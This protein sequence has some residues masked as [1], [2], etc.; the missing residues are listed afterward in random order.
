MFSFHF[1]IF[2]RFSSPF[3]CFL[4]F[5][6][7]IIV[8][9]FFFIIFSIQFCRFFRVLFVLFCSNLP[10]YTCRNNFFLLLVFL[11][12]YFI[13]FCLYFFYVVP[14]ITNKTIL[15]RSMMAWLASHHT[16]VSRSTCIYSTGCSPCQ[17]DGSIKSDSFLK[18]FF[19]VPP[20]IIDFCNTV[21]LRFLSKPNM[22]N[23]RQAVIAAA[24]QPR[25]ANTPPGSSSSLRAVPHSSSDSS[26]PEGQL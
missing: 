6:N 25:A 7:T 9:W 22:Q 20:L 2:R 11:V 8:A 24:I 15:R 1:I 26:K 21:F 13:F 4:F 3:S 18:S 10:E 12:F 14:I 16:V 23:I 19:K 17:E 5:C